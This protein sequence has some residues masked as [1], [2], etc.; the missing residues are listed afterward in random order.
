[1]QLKTDKMNEGTVPVTLF[2]AIEFSAM[3][4]HYLSGM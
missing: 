4:L 1:M 2:S 3:I